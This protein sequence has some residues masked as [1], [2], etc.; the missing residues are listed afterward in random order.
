M[1]TWQ[2][3]VFKSSDNSKSMTMDMQL[4]TKTRRTF[5]TNGMHFV[6]IGLAA[7]I[8]PQLSFSDETQRAEVQLSALSARQEVLAK[9]L[10]GKL[11]APCCF[12]QTVA[13]H[14][15][16][17]AAHIKQQIRQFLAQGHTEEQILD[18]YVRVYGERILSEPRARGFNL[19]AYLA[20][21]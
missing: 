16:D 7:V 13:D 15:S 20:P 14:Y 11:I 19:L 10:E 4:M 21:R 17:A 6:Q 9:Q 12:S 2:T 18:S 8:T 5:L 3:L 1:R